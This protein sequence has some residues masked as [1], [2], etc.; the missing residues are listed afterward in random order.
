MEHVAQ[1]YNSDPEREWLR[2]VKDP[3]SSLEYLVAWH[4]LEKYLPGQGAVPDAG[5]G[6]GRYA[7]ELCRRG[8]QV[9]LFDLSSAELALAWEKFK[10]EPQ[11]VQA[12]LIE[13]IQGDMRDLSRFADDSF[14][15]VLS[16]GGPLTHIPQVAERQQALSELARVTRPGGLIALSVVGYLA[17]LRT[18]LLD[19]SHEPLEPYFQE[20]TSNGNSLGPA[21]MTW[22]FYRADEIRLE[23][24]AAGLVTLG[25][26]GGKGLS[27][28]LLEA[29]NL[30][31]QDEAK[32]KIW[33]NV[34][35]KTCQEPAVVDT[36]EHIL[37][38]G[39]KPTA[40]PSAS[41]LTP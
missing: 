20:L 1:A 15:V 16:L 11:A 39:R 37:W 17:V 25:M 3:Y 5:G 4:M 12:R 28:N 14:D 9:A 26:A 24:E 13:C 34:I 38:I 36:S 8:Y 2:L 35:L 18:I 32:W 7:L 10:A 19:C 30:L 22:H 31:A 29:T 41:E 40:A 33:V 27:S 21:G 6:P 23:A